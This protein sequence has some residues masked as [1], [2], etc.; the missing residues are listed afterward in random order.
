MFSSIKSVWYKLKPFNFK[1][2][3]LLDCWIA[4]RDWFWH[5]IMLEI[6]YFNTNEFPV[7]N[8][9]I[10]VQKERRGARGGGGGGKNTTYVLT[11]C[12]PVNPYGEKTS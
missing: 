9:N 2:P 1:L 3:Y 6:A 8:L 4:W 7:K 10:S 5:A 12:R 11:D